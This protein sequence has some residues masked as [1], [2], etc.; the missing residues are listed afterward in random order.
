M[1]L[2]E[3]KNLIMFQ[4][5][6]DAEDI[7]DYLPHITTYINEGYSLLVNAWCG[8]RADADS[9]N[10]PPLR[11]DKSRNCLSGHIRPLRTGPPGCATATA[12]ATSRLAGFASVKP[13]KAFSPPCAA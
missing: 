11:H 3:L 9:D 7:G 1:T 4:C 8:E 12:T 13:P 2:L 5:N 6:N 10:Y